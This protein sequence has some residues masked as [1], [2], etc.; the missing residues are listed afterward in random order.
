MRA[1]HAAL[2][3]SMQLFVRAATATAAGISAAVTIAKENGPAASQP[4]AAE[5]NHCQLPRRQCRPLIS[6]DCR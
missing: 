2:V 4:A 3:N 5:T 6:G 1:L